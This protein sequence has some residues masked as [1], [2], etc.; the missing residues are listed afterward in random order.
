MGLGADMEVC[1]IF[2]KQE[3]MR[4]DDWIFLEDQLSNIFRQKEL[5]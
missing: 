1:M 4:Q 5:L 2:M 3:A